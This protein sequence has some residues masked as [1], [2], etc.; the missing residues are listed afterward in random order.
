MVACAL[1]PVLGQIDEYG[2]YHFG[3]IWPFLA[4]V[5]HE[6]FWIVFLRPK[7][8]LK[9]FLVIPSVRRTTKESISALPYRVLS[10]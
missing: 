1:K 4:L 2:D 5:L 3:L 10:L 9:R 7:G 6:P 8:R